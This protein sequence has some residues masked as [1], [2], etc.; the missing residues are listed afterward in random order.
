MHKD[1]RWIWTVLEIRM[2]IYHIDI[3]HHCEGQY[4]IFVMRELIWRCELLI[5]NDK[6]VNN[7]WNYLFTLNGS[8]QQVEHWWKRCHWKILLSKRRFSIYNRRFVLNTKSRTK[9]FY[10]YQKLNVNLACYFRIF[11]A[12]SV[13][14]Y[15]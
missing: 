10:W 1:F 8:I 7:E 3:N 9:R 6:C 4:F 13:L 5:S 2:N 11:I 15:K 12:P 14:K